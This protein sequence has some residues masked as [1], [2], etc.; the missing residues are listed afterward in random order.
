MAK[1]LCIAQWP[2][3]GE[4]HPDY[5][6]EFELNL[7]PDESGK[8]MNGGMVLR[9]Q[10]DVDE[11][12]TVWLERSGDILRRELNRLVTDLKELLLDHRKTN[13]TFVPITPSF[14]LWINSLSDEQYRIIIWLDMQDD[15][16]GASNIGFQGMRFMSNRARLMGFVRSLE[17]ELG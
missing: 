6:V 2:N 1:L 10:H 4:Y 12:K 8:W 7:T 5:P 14:E 13:L 17:H 16:G 15:F 11:E 9:V 3:D